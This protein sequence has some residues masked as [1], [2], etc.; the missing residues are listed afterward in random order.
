MN[1]NW[2]VNLKPLEDQLT[3]SILLIPVLPSPI[4]SKLGRFDLK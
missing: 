1:R 2:I 4:N 3:S